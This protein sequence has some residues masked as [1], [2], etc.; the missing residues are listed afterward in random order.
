MSSV[1]NGIISFWNTVSLML[2]LY[3]HTDGK[4]HSRLKSHKAR[5]MSL[6]KL[7][8]EHG[9]S[10]NMDSRSPCGDR[11]AHWLKGGLLVLMDAASGNSLTLKSF[12]QTTM[13]MI[14]KKSSMNLPIWRKSKHWQQR[15][16]LHLMEALMQKVGIHHWVYLHFIFSLI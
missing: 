6:W 2:S 3:G 8:N 12:F 9:K 4:G 10:S 5:L 14:L 11:T 1:L 13:P 16:K 7:P 15:G